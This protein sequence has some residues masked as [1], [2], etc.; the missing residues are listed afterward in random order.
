MINTS[1]HWNLQYIYY[2]MCE[3]SKLLYHS[4]SKYNV[5]I[6]LT[7]IIDICFVSLNELVSNFLQHLI[8]IETT[9]NRHKAV[10]T[11]SFE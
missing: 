2:L 11:L 7:A 1:V 6:T 3:Q 9:I 4:T 10:T 8:V 5:L